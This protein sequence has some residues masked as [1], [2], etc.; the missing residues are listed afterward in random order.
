MVARRASKTIESL[1][2]YEWPAQSIYL[3]CD[4][5]E[6][7]VK[8]SKSATSSDLESETDRIDKISLRYL[9]KVM[10]YV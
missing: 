5:G 7:V 9:L 10:D 6:H 8:M 2:S 1:R 4:S 3:F